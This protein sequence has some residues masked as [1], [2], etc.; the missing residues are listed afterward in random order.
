MKSYIIGKKPPIVTVTNVAENL[1]RIKITNTDE[2][3]PISVTEVT[4]TSQLSLPTGGVYAMATACLRDIGTNEAC[5]ANGTLSA[6]VP[7]QSRTISLIGASMNTYAMKESSVEMD[8]YVTS[9]NIFPTGGQVDVT[10]DSVS[11]LIDGKTLTE[12]FYGLSTAKSSYK[13]NN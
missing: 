10:V 8:L 4:I 6:A 2:N 13:K 7:G 12:K 3:Y 9:N 1:F 5:G 11:Y